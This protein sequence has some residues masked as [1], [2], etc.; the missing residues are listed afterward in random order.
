MK[1]FVVMTTTESLLFCV[2]KYFTDLEPYKQ[3]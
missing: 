3:F 2:I 1:Y